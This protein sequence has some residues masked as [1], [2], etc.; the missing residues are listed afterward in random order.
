MKSELLVDVWL[1][2]VAVKD[3]SIPPL[4]DQVW[5][6]STQC[7]SSVLLTLSALLLLHKATK[8]VLQLLN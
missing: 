3:Y 2:A 5:L 7:P 1:V 4:L 6:L 8:A